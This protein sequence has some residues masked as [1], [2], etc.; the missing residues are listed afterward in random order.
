MNYNYI[1]AIVSVLI[2]SLVSFVGIAF[3]S[4][5]T[6]KLNKWVH[7]IVSFAVGA[8]LGNAFLHLLPEAYNFPTS[9]TFTSFLIFGGILIMFLMEKVFHWDH[10][11]DLHDHTHSNIKSFGYVSLVTD[12]IHNLS[13]GLLIG[14]A[15]LIN[16]EVGLAVTLAIVIHEIPQEISDF[17]ILLH[18][19]FSRKKALLVNFLSACSA[20]VGT[21]IALFLGS[22]SEAAT[23]VILPLAAGGFIYLAGSDLIPELQKTNSTKSTFQQVLLIISGFLLIYFTTS[24]HG[25]AHENDSHEHSEQLHNVPMNTHTNPTKPEATEDHNCSDGD[26]KH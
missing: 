14:A 19:G 4:I 9:A 6:E 1:Y 15:W 16:A 23:Y 12:A 26:H 8:I 17:S 13:D 3:L 2:V 5:K 22:K 24:S 7:N 10:N 20:I 11:H 25:H 18:A 21:I